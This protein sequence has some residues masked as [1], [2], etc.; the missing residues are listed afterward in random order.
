[1]SVS[2]D[3]HQIAIVPTSLIIHC[4]S[5]SIIMLQSTTL[6]IEIIK[7]VVFWMYNELLH[8]MSKQH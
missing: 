3:L 5:S 6:G 4:I 2:Y 8:D 7:Y 1:M